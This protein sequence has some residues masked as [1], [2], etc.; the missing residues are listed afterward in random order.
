[1]MNLTKPFHL[2]RGDKIAT[3]R[4]FGGAVDKEILWIYY[5]GKKRL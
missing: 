4:C 5:Q 2:E 1:M 3:V